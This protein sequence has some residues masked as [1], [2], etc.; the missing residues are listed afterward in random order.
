MK[1]P[2]RTII[3][4]ETA[5]FCMGVKRAV[6]TAT[7][8]LDKGQGPVYTFGPLIHNP[9]VTDQLNKK[10]VIIINKNKIPEKGTIIIRAHG[11]TPTIHN[12]LKETGVHI[13]NATCPYVIKVQNIISKYAKQGYSIIIVGDRGHAEAESY[14]GYAN[15]KGTVIESLE[16]LQNFLKNINKEKYCVV[17]QTTQD[18]DKYNEITKQLSKTFKNKS[19]PCAQGR[20]KLIIHNTICNATGHRQKEAVE[21][22]KKVD[23][24]LV[25]GGRNSANTIRL[26]NKCKATGTPTHFIEKAAELNLKEIIH[27][28]TIGITAGASTPQEVMK[29]IA[30]YIQCNT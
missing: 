2:K 12:K 3:V 11:I 8:V 7:N 23:V 27:Y 1:K 13:Y 24:M 9:Q 10:G 25:V 17:A 30:D 15:G 5:G 22:S 29:E 4:A 28:K 16:E 18:V 20:D 6:D 26:F 21:L 14:L 19:S